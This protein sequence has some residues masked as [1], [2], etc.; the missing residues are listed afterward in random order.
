[1]W[2]E[3]TK[4]GNYKLC[5]RYTDPISG[6]KRKASLT[7]ENDSRAARKAAEELLRE[8]IEKI[9]AGCDDEHVLTLG[10][11][12]EYYIEAQKETVRK[13]TWTRN[14]Y[15]L[16]HALDI[17][18]K[19][20]PIDQISAKDIITRLKQSGKPN[21]TL[22][23]YIMRLKA[24]LRWGYESEYLENISFVDRIKTFPDKE[25][26]EKLQDK[27]LESDELD[28]LLDS[29]KDTRWKLLTQFLALSGLR[30][31]EAMALNDSDIDGT[32]IHVTKTYQFVDQVIEEGVKTDSSCRDVFIQPE[33]E[34]CISKI[35]T[36]RKMDRARCGYVSRLFI[37][38]KDGGILSYDAYRV[39][40][41]RRSREIGH[42]IT[43]HALRHTH[44]SLLAEQGVP[45]D[46][47]SRRVG[48]ADSEITR[49]IYLHITEKR[50]DKDNDALKN[51]RL[52]G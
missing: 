48:H 40:L 43:P 20:T 27:Y 4:Q 52:L 6:R 31:G 28:A 1:M 38:W 10:E 37:P 36:F 44:V 26:K 5:E 41:A 32:Y 42:E 25:K 18:G 15:T 24:M 39:Y 30:I 17:I 33:L 21:S 3:K 49:K 29:M 50:R 47:I 46:V 7:I 19:D 16:D 9:F 23:G 8:K 12:K 2:I 35:R 51:I 22:N 11:L 13:Q 34:K 14:D 45:L